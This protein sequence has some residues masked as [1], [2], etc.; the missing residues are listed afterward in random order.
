MAPAQPTYAHTHKKLLTR[1]Q[2][3][4]FITALKRARLDGD[5]EHTIQHAV[6]TLLEQGLSAI[7]T[8]PVH[9]SLTHNTDGYIA[10]VEKGLPYALL[11][12]CKRDLNFSASKHDIAQVLAQVCSYLRNIATTGDTVPTVTVV[13]DLDEIFAIPTT[14]LQPHINGNYAWE[15]HAPSGMHNDAALM[16][17]LIND[18]NIRPYVHDIMRGFDADMF[19]WAVDAMGLNEPPVKAAVNET[20]IE[21]V[22]LRFKMEVL[23]TD[24]AG[25]KNKD[26]ITL[27]LDILRGDENVYPHPM[28]HNTLVWHSREITLDTYRFDHFWSQYVK[29]DYT[30]DE[31]KSLTRMADTLIEESD[32]RFSGDYWTPPVW[33]DKSHEYIEDALGEDWKERYIVWD[34]AAGALNLTRDY[35]CLLYTS[36]AADDSTEV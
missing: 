16:A 7:Y 28:K 31:L 9:A 30:L 18:A 19:I 36:D 24:A 14:L 21:H 2:T 8:T 23:G 32:R 3:E 29:G 35:R 5:A 20:S 15:T 33:V 26:E 4:A 12:E 10:P 27:F 34:P 25:L 17:A 6:K 22:F 11:I 1:A 13:C